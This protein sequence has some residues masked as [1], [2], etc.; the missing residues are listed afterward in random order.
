LLVSGVGNAAFN[1]S[2]YSL[3]VLPI[4]V[5]I[6]VAA[7]THLSA[8]SVRLQLVV[9]AILDFENTSTVEYTVCI[10]THIVRGPPSE[11]GKY[12]SESSCIELMRG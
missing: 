8:I 10:L 1:L 5:V 7:L 9:T 2:T 11:E 12:A 4:L 3:E 6:D